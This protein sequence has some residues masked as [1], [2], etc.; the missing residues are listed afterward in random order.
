M[1]LSSLRLE[2]FLSGPR[3]PA[4][5]A[6]PSQIARRLAVEPKNREGSYASWMANNDTVVK[7]D[8]P[9]K[10]RGETVAAANSM[11]NGDLAKF[12]ACQ[13]DKIQILPQPHPPGLG[14]LG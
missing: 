9:S 6:R 4:E 1:T 2:C 12:R 3:V 7:Y 5:E 8:V 10:T 11:E 14:V 13:G